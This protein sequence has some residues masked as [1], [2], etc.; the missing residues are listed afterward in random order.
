MAVGVVAAVAAWW[1]G[2]TMDVE[3]TRLIGL[4]EMRSRLVDVVVLMSVMALFVVFDV[5]RR[6]RPVARFS[7]ILQVWLLLSLSLFAALL[8]PV[9]FVSTLAPRVAAL[10]SEATIAVLA[11]NNYWSL[12]PPFY[13]A[14][15][16]HAGIMA[17]DIHR[18]EFARNATAVVSAMRKF[19]RPDFATGHDGPVDAEDLESIYS[20]PYPYG[21]GYAQLANNLPLALTLAYRLQHVDA[22]Q[23]YRH[24]DG[25]GYQFPTL[26][27]IGLICVSAGLLGAA[28]MSVPMQN[29]RNLPRGLPLYGF[30]RLDFIRNLA[31]DGHLAK[32]CPIIWSSRAHGVALVTL[33][34]GLAMGVVGNS[35][36]R[37]LARL[38]SG[39][40][41]VT[42]MIGLLIIGN[43][44]IVYG[45]QSAARFAPLPS[46]RGEFGVFV[47]QFFAIFLGLRIAVE[48]GLFVFGEFAGNS[49]FEIRR[50]LNDVSMY[51]AL[52]AVAM[53]AARTVSIAALLGCAVAFIG[54]EIA[55]FS[56]SSPADI[57]WNFSALAFAVALAIT[58]NRP[59][60]GSGVRR[61]TVCLCMMIVPVCLGFIF[62][63]ID[64]SGLVDPAQLTRTDALLRELPVLG[65]MA[66]VALVLRLTHETR[67]ALAY[68]K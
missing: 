24:G 53:Q 68:T 59:S 40:G 21:H 33:I 47:I 15:Q 25:T 41:Y 9:V 64:L 20:E 4:W 37:V 51:S 35:W 36:D 49:R 11:R 14:Q 26:N 17:M 3:P 45:T 13:I 12:M 62:S 56:V 39:S 5:V 19:V 23:R 65:V 48:I 58:A 38:G 55:S 16:P 57:F 60:M 6:T 63:R 32:L 34:V 22:A 54:M 28:L 43:L 66:G 61:F 7:Q 67:R 42:A 1:Y 44:T 10:E 2:S 52:A 46:W 27:V 50:I 8:P 30:A 29:I 18:N 31:I